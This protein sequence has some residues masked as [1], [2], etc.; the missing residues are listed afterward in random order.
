MTAAAETLFTPVE[1]QVLRLAAKGSERRA[2]IT[3]LGRAVRRAAD[4]LGGRRS[5]ARLANPRLEALRDHAAVLSGGG[6]ADEAPLVAAGFSP[7]Q[8]AALR[9]HVVAGPR[10]AAARRD[11]MIYMS[12][13]TLGLASITS[14]V[15]LTGAL[16]MSV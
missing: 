4:A 1:Q 15:G 3:P 16:V 14:F 5:G 10:R 9:A 2:P 8:I 11:R 12:G 13:I 7:A 6:V